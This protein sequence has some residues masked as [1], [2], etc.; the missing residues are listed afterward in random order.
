M[1]LMWAP[2]SKERRAFWKIIISFPSLFKIGLISQRNSTVT[3][4][5]YG[6]PGPGLER[7]IM[8]GY[9]N[10]FSGFDSLAIV[11]EDATLCE[12]KVATLDY[13]YFFSY[14]KSLIS[15]TSHP[16]LHD[17]PVIVPK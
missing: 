14:P 5:D 16:F 7:Q 8:I 2:V 10:L 4:Y 17:C 3:I 6:G 9:S 13:L 1:T 15:T 11:E 12:L